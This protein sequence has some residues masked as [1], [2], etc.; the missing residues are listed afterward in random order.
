MPESFGPNTTGTVIDGSVVPAGIGEVALAGY[1]QL[2]LV[3]AVAEQS[4]PVPVGVPFSVPAG[5]V[6]V[7]VTGWTSGP[8][9]E[10]AASTGSE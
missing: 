7:T 4:H 10:P 9:S 3:P 1:V 8:T 6:S 5:R 2:T